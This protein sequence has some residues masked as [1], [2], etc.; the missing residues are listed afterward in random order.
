VFGVLVGAGHRR[1]HLHCGI[2]AAARWCIG[3]RHLDRR[4]TTP[5]AP[6]FAWTRAAGRCAAWV[7]ARRVDW[8]FTGENGRMER[9]RRHPAHDD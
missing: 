3:D 6:S 5:R 7:A 4:P 2:P 1:G 8:R 9:K